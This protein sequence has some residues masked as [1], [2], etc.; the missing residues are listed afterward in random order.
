MQN[1]SKKQKTSN[2]SPFLTLDLLLDYDDLTDLWQHKDGFWNLYLPLN[3]KALIKHKISSTDV[4]ELMHAKLPQIFDEKHLSFTNVGSKPC[5]KCITRISETYEDKE[6]GERDE[7]LEELSDYFSL[8]TGM[9]LGTKSEG[10]Y[11]KVAEEQLYR[12][13][14][15]VLDAQKL[16]QDYGATKGEQHKQW[17]LGEIARTLVDSDKEFE[18]VFAESNREHWNEG[19]AP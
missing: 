9:T 11:D 18:I 5:L 8:V 13:T 4:V 12:M 17:L 14:H 7:I 15:K 16:L 19:V 6:K 2:V 10:D 3:S 1:E